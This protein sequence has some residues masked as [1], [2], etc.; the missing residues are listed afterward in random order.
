VLWFHASMASQ[1]VYCH[2][3]RTSGRSPCPGWGETPRRVWA[4]F[5]ELPTGA[6]DRSKGC[7]RRHLARK[8]ASAVPTLCGLSNDLREA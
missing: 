4:K 7:V 5:P 6:R 1:C 8:G 2:G 3:A